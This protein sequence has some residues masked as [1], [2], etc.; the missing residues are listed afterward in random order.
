ME[1]FALTIS[2]TDF[3][4]CST[5]TERISILN[6]LSTFLCIGIEE[7][8]QSFDVYS[9]CSILIPFMKDQLKN[10]NK[11]LKNNLKNKNLEYNLE[12][13]NLESLQQLQEEFILIVRTLALIL[14]LVPRSCSVVLQYSPIGTFLELL[15]LDNSLQ[16]LNLQNFIFLNE[17]LLEEI[18]KC[19]EKITMEEPMKL[20]QKENNSEEINDDS[21]DAESEDKSPMIILLNFINLPNISNRLKKSIFSI[22]SNVFR[23]LN[24][25]KNNFEK[26]LQKLIFCLN[27]NLKIALDLSINGTSDNLTFLEM[28]VNCFCYFFEKIKSHNFYNKIIPEDFVNLLFDNLNLLNNLQN[29]K[30]NILQVIIFILNLL[31][32]YYDVTKNLYFLQ[33]EKN[34]NIFCNFL[35]KFLD[36]NQF[37]LQKKDENLQNLMENTIFYFL[38]KIFPPIKENTLQ[39]TL[40]LPINYLL[41]D[42]HFYFWEDDYHNWNEYDE[43]TCEILDL[44]FKNKKNLENISV[45]ILGRFYKIN[46]IEMKQFSSANLMRNIKRDPLPYLYHREVIFMEENL[47]QN[48]LQ[49]I[50][51]VDNTLQNNTL[52]DTLQNNS[53]V[54][55]DNTLQNDNKNDTTTVSPQTTE[56]F[57]FFKRLFKK[58]KTIDNNVDSNNNNTQESKTLSTTENTTASSSSSTTVTTTTNEKTKTSRKKEKKQKKVA[59]PITTSSSNSSNTTTP[60]FKNNRR[61]NNTLQNSVTNE[62]LFLN[63]FNQE[64]DLDVTSERLSNLEKLNIYEYFIV[65]CWEVFLNHFLQQKNN[66]CDSFILLNR[67]VNGY[68]NCLQKSLQNKIESD[69]KQ[70]KLQFIFRKICKFIVTTLQNVVNVDKNTQKLIPEENVDNFTTNSKTMSLIDFNS[71]FGNDLIVT[72]NCLWLIHLLLYNL[73]NVDL[74]NTLQKIMKM[75]EMNETLQILVTKYS[76]HNNIHFKNIVKNCDILLQQ[77]FTKMESDDN[78]SQFLEIVKNPEISSFLKL[79]E[80]LE[81]I[82]IF[83]ILKTK[84]FEEF[85]KLNL[86]LENCNVENFDNFKNFIVKIHFYLKKNFEKEISKKIISNLVE[87]L[88]TCLEQL[89]VKYFPIW[90]EEDILQKRKDFVNVDILHEKENLSQIKI[91][92]LI[93]CQ[94]L[95]NFIKEKLNLDN[96]TIFV[97]ENDNTKIELNFSP[98][99]TFMEM[100]FKSLKNFNGIENSPNLENF[101]NLFFEKEKYELFIVK[102]TQKSLQKSQEFNFENLNEFFNFE[103]LEKNYFLFTNLEKNLFSLF[104]WIFNFKK[105]F[106]KFNLNLEICNLF[107]LLKIL[108]IVNQLPND[109]PNLENENLEKSLQNLQIKEELK[110]ESILHKK[111]QILQNET[112]TISLQNN[113]IPNLEFYQINLSNKI[114]QNF[115]IF[116]MIT[117]TLPNWVNI[118]V[119]YCSNFILPFTIRHLKI[120][121]MLVN[122]QMSIQQ[123]VTNNSQNNL[124]RNSNVTNKLQKLKSHKIIIQDRNKMLQQLQNIYKEIFPLKEILEIE[125]ENEIGTGSGPTISFFDEMSKNLQKK[126]LSIW[127]DQSPITL[128]NNT[129]STNNE[130]LQNTLQNNTQTLQQENLNEYVVSNFGLFPILDK[131]I[132]NEEIFT[133]IGSFISKTIEDSKLIDFELNLPFLECLLQCNEFGINLPFLTIFD[134]KRISP[135]LFNSLISILELL[136]KKKSL[137]NGLQKEKELREEIDNLFL[138]FQFGEISLLENNFIES[139][140]F[141]NLENYVTLFVKYLCDKSLQKPLQK[142]SDGMNAIFSLVTNNSLQ[143]NFIQNNLIFTP[144]E[145]LTIISGETKKNCWESQ[146]KNLLLECINCQHGYTLQSQVIQWFIDF[147]LELSGMEQRWF[148]QFV[149]GSSRVPIGGLRAL[150][151][152]LTIVKKTMEIIDNL[153]NTQIGDEKVTNNLIRKNSDNMLPTCNTCF[154]YFKLPEYSNYEILKEKVMLAI[155]QGR[156]SFDL[157]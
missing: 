73:G 10:L 41:F 139:V 66:N 148:L 97:K 52:Q 78:E 147:L 119:N 98:S 95:K 103:N 152:K 150:Q 149:T 35:N 54:N 99:C 137:Q 48:L 140:T 69:N 44:N 25:Q 30:K 83:K 15:I 102:N 135:N 17:N 72:S 55:V 6:E 91:D 38:F 28:I 37:Y 100:I 121:P 9:W 22:I 114:L 146:D 71:K 18:V 36:C 156:G 130:E 47:S 134:Y 151:P 138:D 131:K 157:S 153:Q 105:E 88:N 122:H 8:I 2:P 74:Q 43:K 108:F 79:F 87:I 63:D 39:K 7:F 61:N 112:F 3:Q 113:L 106:S 4:N 33:N 31:I 24:L 23:K 104:L 85:L 19:L 21:E 143:N 32:N 101:I 126:N 141:D 86:N 64:F 116:R 65:N 123:I 92:P 128:Q 154:H 109:L 75:E 49:N 124:S 84:I 40:Q 12:S 94:Q 82:S 144:Q 96:F 111:L 11:N 93:T 5:S 20:L 27:E 42:K 117:H 132:E 59:P 68:C 90:K 26:D 34:L 57:G 120:L 16:K 29:F 45:N 51:M 58:Q 60:I 136:E 46:L 50:P 67:I 62:V 56:N 89:I 14:D 118:I 125:Y 70:E 76:N 81:N 80:N 155:K 133:L 1:E 129:Q 127:L 110:N 107:I 77:D 53:I 13:L 142:I 115:S 145:F